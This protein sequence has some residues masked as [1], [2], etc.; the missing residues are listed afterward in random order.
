MPDAISSA[1]HLAVSDALDVLRRSVAGL[2]SEALNWEPA[3]P[4]TN[5]I[6]VLTVHALA[7]TRLLIH[8]GLGLEQPPRDR[9]AEFATVA[10]DAPGLLAHIDANGAA[11]LALLETAPDS[12]DW[13][14]PRRMVRADG[15]ST[16]RSAAFWIIHAA[17]HLRGHADEAALTRHVWEHR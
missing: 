8:L 5:S 17:D 4:E 9:P 15:S 2:D 16:E 7:A 12:V 14:A 3:G 13:S 6:A 11:C 1:V 10:D